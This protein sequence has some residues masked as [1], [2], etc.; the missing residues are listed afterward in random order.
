MTRTSLLSRVRLRT[1]IVT[2]VGVGA[3]AVVVSCDPLQPLQV[4]SED[5]KLLSVSLAPDSTNIALSGADTVRLAVTLHGKGSGTISGPVPAWSVG[6]PLIISIDATGLIR[7]LRA[8]RSE[9]MAT[10]NGKRGLAVVVVT[11]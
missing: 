6:N 10:V 9:V 1:A 8:G 3:L 2:T 7:G 5:Q 11:P 4:L